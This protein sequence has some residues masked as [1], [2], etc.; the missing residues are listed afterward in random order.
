VHNYQVTP[1]GTLKILIL[2]LEKYSIPPLLIWSS[3]FSDSNNPILCMTPDN[4]KMNTE[5]NATPKK[6]KQCPLVYSFYAG[7]YLPHSWNVENCD[8][9]DIM[10]YT[11]A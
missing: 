9:M 11:Y 7:I 6:I 10:T 4:E 2:N 8:K 3:T 1:Q 5:E